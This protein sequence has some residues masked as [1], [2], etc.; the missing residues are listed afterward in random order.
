[1]SRAE[2]RRN[3]VSASLLTR[4]AVE[5]GADRERL[6]RNTGLDAAALADPATEVRA[7]Q[8]L[9][10]VRNLIEQL[11]DRPGLGLDAGLGYPCRPTASGDSRC[12]RAPPCAR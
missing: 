11:G 5:R 1:M 10:L 3:V 6:L 9:Q 8:E 12:W 4:F 2:I 7:A